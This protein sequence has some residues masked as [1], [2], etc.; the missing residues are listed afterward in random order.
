MRERCTVLPGLAALFFSLLCGTE[1]HAAA[2]V[3]LV[4]VADRQAP[5][6]AGHTWIRELGQAGVRNVRLRQGKLKDRPAI[7]VRGTKDSPLYVVT[8]V[9]DSRG[10]L[11]LPGGRYHDGDARR[12]AAWL[13]DLARRGPPESREPVVGF[14]LTQSQMAA[15][16]ADLATPIELSTRGK[17]RAGVV[18]KL[19][20]LLKL[21]VRMDAA[22]LAADADNRV[23]DELSGLSC[24]T[25]LAAVLRPAGL[26]LVPHVGSTGPEYLVTTARAQR[27]TWPVGHKPQERVTQVLPK[28]YEP[29]TVGL[30]GVS[31]AKTL[32]EIGRRLEIPVLVDHA[33]LARH[34]VDL[35]KTIK[36]PRSRT[37]YAD[38]LD[39]ALFQAGLKCSLR[40][41]E[42][43]RP[44]LWITTLR[45]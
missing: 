16:R 3:E 29:V 41:D 23:A 32:D 39:R 20:G 36:V 30:D 40:T 43:G 2:R 18:R 21:P 42:A 14:G 7:E 10:Q 19:A 12:I 38:A 13:N 25:G 17:P 31:V 8:G 6:V 9:L 5:P 22:L 37:T 11:V 27:E 44:F 34:A 15:V 24:G 26:A 28:F 4:V 1:V 33:A 45:L 35:D